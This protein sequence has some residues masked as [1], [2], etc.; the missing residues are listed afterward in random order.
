MTS[1]AL[2]DTAAGL[3]AQA[4]NA[5]TAAG[6]TPP[7]RRY[8]SAGEPAWDDE[9]LVV[10]VDSFRW[11]LPQT[12]GIAVAQSPALRTADLIV[13]ITRC[14]PGPDEQGQPPTA[15][16]LDAS[17]RTLLVE[18]WTVFETLAGLAAER[19]LNGCGSVAVGAAVLV[20]PEGGLADVPLRF[21]YQI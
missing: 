8:V 7:D 12:P 4:V 16:L 6:L 17:S 1:T 18:A 19:L 11:G 2:Y 20:G 13:H 15:A 14:M 21:S 5:Y 3:L 9:Q 10:Q